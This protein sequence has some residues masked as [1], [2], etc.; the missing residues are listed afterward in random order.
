VNEAL[1]NSVWNN[2]K[3][4]S[5]AEEIEEAIK[6][7][8]KDDNSPVVED[9]DYKDVWLDDAGKVLA[10]IY[11]NRGKAMLD[12]EGELMGPKNMIVIEELPE[13][14]KGTYVES[15]YESAEAAGG[16]LLVH[17]YLQQWQGAFGS[18]VTPANHFIM[19]AIPFSKS[20]AIHE[21]RHL[22]DWHDPVFWQKV[23]AV[24]RET[25]NADVFETWRN[26]SEINAN[27]GQ[28]KYYLKN[29]G[30]PLL[31]PSDISQLL[32][33]A[34]NYSQYSLRLSVLYQNSNDRAKRFMHLANAVGI[35]G[36]T[37]MAATAPLVPFPVFI[38]YL[39]IEQLE[40]E[41]DSP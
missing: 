23:L 14:W 2:P 4:K 40:K 3:W 7:T 22:L 33:T 20:T 6:K 37:I 17:P 16:K 32:N 15:I 27:M 39:L 10:H 25:G 12:S 41:E 9:L 13:I 38:I 18:F 31:N 36:G 21:V 8:A 5:L 30:A 1:K 24:S 34:V 11:G 19:P 26:L 35:I 28:F 29:V